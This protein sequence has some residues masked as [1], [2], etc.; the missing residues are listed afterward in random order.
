MRER[1]KDDF[2]GRVIAAIDKQNLAPPLPVTSI[3]IWPSGEAYFPELIADISRAEKFVHM[4]YFIWERDELT[5]TICEVLIDRLKAGVEVRI[6]NDFLGNIQYKKDQLARVARRG[7]PVGV[8][9]VAD[10]Q[11][12]TT[13][14]IARSP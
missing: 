2:Q 12:R 4:Q 3:D 11:A 7:R 13:A 6:L 5:E 10:R 8:D 14:T 9:H 1:T